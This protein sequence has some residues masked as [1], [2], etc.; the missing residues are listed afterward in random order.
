MV[1]HFVLD[2]VVCATFNTF[3]KVPTEVGLCIVQSEAT[4]DT[5]C[6]LPVLG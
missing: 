1:Q 4:D 2:V 3:L 6:V 5:L